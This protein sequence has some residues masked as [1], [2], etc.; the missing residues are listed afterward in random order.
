LSR[1]TRWISVFDAFHDGE[2][3]A[4][5]TAFQLM[6]KPERKEGFLSHSGSGFGVWGRQVIFSA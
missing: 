3:V 4:G 5:C 1:F 2:Q 6:E